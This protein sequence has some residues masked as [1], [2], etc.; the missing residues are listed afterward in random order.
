MLT[1]RASHPPARSR[2]AVRSASRSSSRWMTA[3][4]STSVAKVSSAPVD[5]S[6]SS[7]PPR[8][9]PRAPD[10]AGDPLLVVDP[11]AE[12]LADLGGVAQPPPGARHVEERL[13]QGERL[14]QR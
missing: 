4:S 13:V 11:G 5:R 14:H 10:R 6:G 7:G 12:V 8:G 3:G 2:P 9:G 1:V